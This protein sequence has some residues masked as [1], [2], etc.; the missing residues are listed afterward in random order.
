M[1]DPDNISPD[2]WEANKEL[3]GEF[4]STREKNRARGRKNRNQGVV[5]E[6]RIKEALEQLGLKRVEKI[7]TGWNIERNGSG[8]IVNAWPQEKA[9]IDFIAI[10]PDGSGRM[11]ICEAKSRAGS[12]PY[13]ALSRLQIG[14]LEEAAALNAI[15]L[16]AW[17][18]SET[19]H[20][21]IMSWPVVGKFHKTKWSCQFKSHTA[22]TPEIAEKNLFCLSGGGE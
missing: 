8:K 18:D 13:S 10:L 7:N 2:V 1:L 9:T 12:L 4:F 15:S 3:L 19:E 5:S 16:L 22:I 20:V 6:N 14:A 17:H 11:V 21:Y